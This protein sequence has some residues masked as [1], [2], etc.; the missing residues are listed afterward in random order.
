VFNSHAI[1]N[2]HATA[3]F[4]KAAL[5]PDKKLSPLGIIVVSSYYMHYDVIMDFVNRIKEFETL[6]T[7]LKKGRL[8]VVFGRRRIGK[9]RMLKRWL[10]DVGGSYTQAIEAA[11]PIQIRQ[12]Y[13]DIR[14]HLETN[15]EPKNW[16]DMFELLNS[17][18]KPIVLCIDE[19]PYLVA[20]DASL[21]SRLQA[22]LDHR[23]Q[24]K[25]SLVLCGSSFHMMHDTFL[26]HGSPL[27]GRAHKI[28]H[29]QPMTYAD[30]CKASKRKLSDPNS[31]NIFALLGGIP[32]YWELAQD[33]TEATACVQDLFFSHAPYMQNEPLKIFKDENIKGNQA[34]SVMEAVGR[35]AH[36]PSEIASRLGIP[37]TQVSKMIYRLKDASVIQRD[38]AFGEPERHPKRVLY[39]ISDPAFRF[40]YSVFSPHR[41]RWSTYTKQTQKKYVYDFASTVFENLCRKQHQPSWRYWEKDIEI[42]FVQ[43][44][45][46]KNIILGEVKYT[47]LT[48]QEK[49]SIEEQLIQKWHATRWANKYHIK[50]CKVIDQNY[51][52]Q[53]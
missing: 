53:L 20:S 49:K 45:D 50:G 30:F 12:I 17:I 23:K 27:Y 4:A 3:L 26:Y 5:H 16:E 13:R 2:I 43:K 35:G 32:K 29:V 19:F 22:W 33:F 39:Q 38:L 6:N 10:S 40:W 21:P 1:F 14:H 28:M 7:A 51:L 41:S 9:T 24:T 8:V 44:L 11:P 37:Q 52:K 15:I 36:R 42:D 34:F 25:L 46:Q 47:K 48:K 18:K 31:F